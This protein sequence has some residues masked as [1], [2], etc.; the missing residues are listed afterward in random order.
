MSRTIASFTI[1]LT[2]VA[3]LASAANAEVAPGVAPAVFDDPC[4]DGSATNCRRHAL[5]GFREAVAAQHRGTATTPLRVSYIGASRTA[6]D[7][8]TARLREHLQAQL[9]DGG[10]GFVFALPPHPFCQHRAVKRS[11]GGAW[12][13][14]GISHSLPGDRLLGLGGSAESSGTSSIRLRPSSSVVTHVEL[15]YLSPPGGGDVTVSGSASESHDLSTQSSTKLAGFGV[16]DFAAPISQLDVRTLGRVRL[17]GVTMEARTGAVVDNLGV[18]NAT[19]KGFLE[20]RREHFRNQLAHRAPSLVVVMLGTNEAEWLLPKGTTIE[21]HE[22]LIGDLAASIRAANPTAAC[23]IVSPFDQLDWRDPQMLPR[24]SIPAI[25]AA[26]HRAAVAHGCAFW[27]AYQWMGGR[28]ASRSWY[29]RPLVTHDC[30]HPT[31][32]GAERI[33]DALFAGL[34]ET[35][36]VRTSSR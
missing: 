26:Q 7:H 36:S 34:W 17:F 29:R 15:H 8:I 35:T 21:E 10:P 6:D 19:V 28:G 23:L 14:R 5:D 31:T 30:Q 11:S 20:D 12:L 32:A 22:H 4:V 2:L 33:A 16:F 3:L 1:Y 27:D 25:V 24:A 9:G 18:V 13:V